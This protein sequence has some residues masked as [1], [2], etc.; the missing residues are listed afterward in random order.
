MSKIKLIFTGT[1]EIGAPLLGELAKD[2][3]FE[4]ILVVTQKD[5]PAGRKM[6]LQSSPIKKTAE[7]LGLPVFQPEDINAAESLER[8]KAVGADLMLV[9]AYGQLVCWNS[10]DGWCLPRCFVPCEE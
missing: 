1:A 4:I 9:F 7:T 3:R 10:P 5:K 6:E 2:N 8:L